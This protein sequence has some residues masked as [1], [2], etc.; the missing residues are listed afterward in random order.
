M[1]GQRFV[2]ETDRLRL[3]PFASDDLA[4]YHAVMSE[5]LVG[6]ELPTGRGFSLEE[7]ESLLDTWVG[8]WEVHGF[9][10]WAVIE[11]DSGDLLGHSGLRLLDDV[12]DPELLYAL[13]SASWGLGYATEAARAG[14]SWALADGRAAALVSYVR[15]DNDRAQRVLDNC[16]FLRA[17]EVSRW[18]LEHYEYRRDLSR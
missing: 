2:V 18:G 14:V 12:S 7:T 5:H 13:R 16:R 9:G 3:R 15:V 8:H 17:G 1:T 6:L 10:P 11:R 4:A